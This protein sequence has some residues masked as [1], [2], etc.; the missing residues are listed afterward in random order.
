VGRIGGEIMSDKELTN[1]DLL[2]MINE[3]TKIINELTKEINEL[4]KRPA[5]VTINYP[6]VPYYS[7]YNEL[8]PW[9]PPWTFISSNTDVA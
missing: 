8:Y 3:L 7:P 9:Q 2:N 1:K 6:Y 5:N 4:K